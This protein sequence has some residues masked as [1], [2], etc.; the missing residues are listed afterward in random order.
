MKNEE[1]MFC[2]CFNGGLS[3]SC[4]VISTFSFV[5]VYIMTSQ[6]SQN[7]PRNTNLCN[8]SLSCATSDITSACCRRSVFGRR[9][10][11]SKMYKF[12]DDDDGGQVIT[13]PHLTLWVR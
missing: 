1:C 3:L 2:D 6:A 7:H 4:L 12:T 11:L 5:I 8:F 13:I 10:N 9:E